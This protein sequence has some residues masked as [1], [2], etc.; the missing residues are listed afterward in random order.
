MQSKEKFPRNDEPSSGPED[1]PYCVELWHAERRDSVERVLGRAV[2]TQFAR[3][4][5]KAAKE[6]HPERRV[7]LRKGNR[8]VAD[9]LTE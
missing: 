7:T 3:T 9:S 1:L 8:I 4:I 6:E 5:F 2:N